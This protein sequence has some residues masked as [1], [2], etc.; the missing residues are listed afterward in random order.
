M[1]PQAVMKTLYCSLVLI[2]FWAA[3]SAHAQIFRWVD[4]N[5]VTHFG[6]TAPAKTNV[7]KINIRVTEPGGSSSRHSYDPNQIKE[8]EQRFL[9]AVEAERRLKQERTAELAER[10]AKQEAYCKKLKN[11]LSYYREGFAMVKRND[12]GVIE[13]I[14]DVQVKAKQQELEALEKEHCT[15]SH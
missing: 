4:E 13:H 10:K 14:P 2:A 5:G 3:S 9:Q 12:E 15:I 8:N 7:E 1:K 11:E 6:D